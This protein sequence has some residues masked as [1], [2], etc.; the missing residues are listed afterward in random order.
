MVY[1]K[2]CGAALVLVFVL[3]LSREYSS[4][5]ERR[6]RE[7]ESFIRLLAHIEK[8]ID[9]YL[10]PHGELFLGFSDDWL[11]KS[12]F[13][14]K[15]REGSGLSHAFSSASDRLAVSEPIKARLAEYFSGF[16]KGYKEAELLRLRECRT[17]VEKMLSAERTELEKNVKVTRALLLGGAAG[18]VILII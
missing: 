11:E 16:G 10:L 7:G 6:A 9:S 14:G 5:A 3:F 2:W 13:L 15:L 12:G 8:M 1:L 18:I 4:Y 17:D